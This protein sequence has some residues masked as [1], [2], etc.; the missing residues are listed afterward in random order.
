MKVLLNEYMYD[1][2]SASKYYD[3]IKGVIIKQDIFLAYNNYQAVN[4]Y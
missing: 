3:I 2:Y 1:L 4:K